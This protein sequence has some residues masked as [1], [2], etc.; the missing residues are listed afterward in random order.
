MGAAERALTALRISCCGVGP[1]VTSMKAARS[2]VA[3][4][5]VLVFALALVLWSRTRVLVFMV[6]LAWIKGWTVLG[7][8]SARPDCFEQSG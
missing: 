7:Q 2:L 4:V 6:L 1:T 8:S 5:P 3:C